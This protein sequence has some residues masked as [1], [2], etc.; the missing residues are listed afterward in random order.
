M[1]AERQFH[2][3]FNAARRK[4][5]VLSGNGFCFEIPTHVLKEAVVVSELIA[6]RVP[7][8][9]ERIDRVDSWLA[10]CARLGTT[11]H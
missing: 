8:T 10:R 4:L 9:Q 3:T 7:S 6:A 1:C 2:K 11:T 5:S